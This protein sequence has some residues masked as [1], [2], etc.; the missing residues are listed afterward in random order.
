MWQVNSTTPTLSNTVTDS[1]GNTARLTFLV[2]TTDA[3]GNAWDQVKLTDP[4]TGKP[5]PYGVL[6]SDYVTSGSTAKV[7]LHD[8]DLKPNTTYVFRTAAFDG[9]QWEAGWSAWTKF[10]TPAA[11]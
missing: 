2:Y 3:N 9:V 4:N 8:G 5:A 1:D 6:V 7:T 10:K 11:P